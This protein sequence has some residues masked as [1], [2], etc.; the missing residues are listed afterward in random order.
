MRL[1]GFNYETRQRCYYVDGHEKSDTKA[2]R[3]KFVRHYFGYEKLMDRVIQIK[4]TGKQK[5][6]EQERIEMPHGHHYIDPATQLKM[7]ELHTN[8]RHSFQDTMNTT[9]TFGGDL[10]VR[11]PEGRKPLICFGQDET[12]MKQY[13]ITSKSW[14]APTGQKAIIPK[15]EGMGLA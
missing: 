1:L 10:S 13:C 6:E 5:L 2:Y 4:L 11:F 8:A 14:T 3:K 9:T 12:I 15:D 7:V